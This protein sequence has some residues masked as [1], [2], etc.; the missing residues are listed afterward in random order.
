MAN[1][2]NV[3]IVSKYMYIVS[4]NAHSHHHHPSSAHV[5][6]HVCTGEVHVCDLITSS[7]CNV[8]AMTGPM[9][10]DLAAALPTG[11]E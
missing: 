4:V 1:T 6:Q 5:H 2:S 8:V 3:C 10:A 9:L 7:T 11:S